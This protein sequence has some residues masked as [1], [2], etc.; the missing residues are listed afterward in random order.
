MCH[1]LFGLLVLLLVFLSSCGF[2]VILFVLLLSFLSLLLFLYLVVFV[3]FC[4]VFCWLCVW[5][6]WGDFLAGG[7]ILCDFL[8]DVLKNFGI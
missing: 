2:G 4:V 1:R 3:S 6:F 8:P 5:Y 7:L